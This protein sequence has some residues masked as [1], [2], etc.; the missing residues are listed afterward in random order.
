M[1]SL[2]YNPMYK[3]KKVQPIKPIEPTKDL[4]LKR[5]ICCKT[6]CKNC[7]WKFRIA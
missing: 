2:S 3:E 5:G 1:N 4:L 7:P 6:G